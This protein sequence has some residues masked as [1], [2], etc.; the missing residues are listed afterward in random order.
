M[1]M[2]EDGIAGGEFLPAGAKM[3]VFGLLGDGQLDPQLVEF[4]G[5]THTGPMLL[6]EAGQAVFEPYVAFIRRNS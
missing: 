1:Q 2:V 3:P 4:E 5:I 6:K